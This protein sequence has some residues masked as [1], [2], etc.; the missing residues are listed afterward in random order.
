MN[1]IHRKHIKVLA[2][3]VTYKDVTATLDAIAQA[4]VNDLHLLADVGG[5]GD[6]PSD[7]WGQ[8]GTFERIENE[9]VRSKSLALLSKLDEIETHRHEI[10]DAIEYINNL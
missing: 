7:Y 6:V 8:D 4:I 2:R 5:V 9:S 3:A 10:W 1:S